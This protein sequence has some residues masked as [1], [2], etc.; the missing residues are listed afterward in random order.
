[1]TA[2]LSS[3]HLTMLL[4]RFRWRSLW[5]GFRAPPGRNR[6]LV[7]LFLLATPAAYAGLLASVFA[8]LRQVASLQVQAAALALIAGVIATASLAAKVAQNDALVAGSLENEFLMTR[9]VSLGALVVAR[10]LAGAV[11]DWS[12]ALFLLPVLLAAVVVWRLGVLGAGLAMATSLL[13]AV[14]VSAAAQLAQILVVHLVPRTRRRMVWT[15]LM[16]L[17]AVGMAGLWM[18]GSAA[19]RAPASFARALEPWADVALHSPAV[20]LAFPLAALRARDPAFAGGLLGLMAVTAM[21]LAL[22][23]RGAVWAGRRG[24]EEAGAPWAEAG[25]GP[26]HG[27]FGPL[28]PFGKDLRLLLRDR[29]RLVALIAAPI[30]FVGV[31]IFGA[32]GWSPSASTGAQRAALA[33]SMAVYMA[34]FGPLGHMEAERQAFWILRSVPVSLGRLLAWKALFWSV[35]VGGSCA[36]TFAGLTVLAQAPWSGAD[37][38][39]GALAVGGAVL[40]SVLAIGLAAGAADCSIDGRAALSPSTVLLFLLVGGLFNVVL[41]GPPD[42]QIRGIALVGITT[43]LL[44]QAGVA[45]AATAFD[46]ERDVV[47]RGGSQQLAA[48]GVLLAI[49]LFLGRHSIMATTML[50]ARAEESALGAVAWAALIGLGVTLRLRHQRG[51]L[52]RWFPLFAFVAGVAAATGLGTAGILP[53]VVFARLLGATVEELVARAAI[54]TGLL[55]TWGCGWRGRCVAMALASAVGAASSSLPMSA[56]TLGVALLV[57]AVRAISGSFWPTWLARM[58]IDISCGSHHLTGA[59]Q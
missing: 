21:V 42:V 35:I 55:N 34:T 17:S 27:G 23:H 3:W 39:I 48:D 9:P 45:R 4:V 37:M 33:Y 59:G 56:G 38:A 54:Q 24:W 57:G 51:G 7:W 15:A 20:L 50:G 11:T 40:L 36:V 16:L 19:L 10:S 14:G 44:W 18:L 25:P 58:A 12:G 49:L 8:T 22:A 28:T 41:L 13:A 2:L 53:S 52:A 29:S 1:M 30:L 43:A 32:A 46:P 47:A 6:R 5:N 26:K 31:Q